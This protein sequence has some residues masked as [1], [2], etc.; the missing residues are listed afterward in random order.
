[1]R[2]VGIDLGEKRIGV[3]ISDSS[4]SLATP[5]EVVTRTGSRD[6]DHR[7]IRAIVE[8][9]EAEIL[10]VGLPLS[11]DGSEGKAA[12][13]ARKEAEAIRQTISIPIELHDERFT[14][15]EAERILKEQG[16]DATERR[17]VV[18]KVAAAILLQAWMEGR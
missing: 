8:E 9:V 16:L 18:D 6:Q 3:A 2:A 10:V 5:Y 17:K 15:V 12:Q 4:G 14:T 7:R 11:L 1:M 13:G